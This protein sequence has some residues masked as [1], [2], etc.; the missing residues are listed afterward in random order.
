[1]LTIRCQQFQQQPLPV[2]SGAYFLSYACPP[3]NVTVS[4]ATSSK[5]IGHW[6]EPFGLDTSQEPP[7]CAQITN[8]WAPLR[9]LG[10]RIHFFDGIHIHQLMVLHTAAWNVAITLHTEGEDWMKHF[11]IAASLYIFAYGAVF[12]SDILTHVCILRR[13]SHGTK[14]EHCHLKT[15][16]I[17]H[18]LND[19]CH[20]Y[21]VV[22]GGCSPS[23]CSA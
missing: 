7:A 12:M 19:S 9:N 3:R 5:M 8:E 15:T 11:I 1:M 22:Q 18:L 13:V 16:S 2:L 4:W 14:D 21:D 17:I 6:D 20:K 10:R 23:Q